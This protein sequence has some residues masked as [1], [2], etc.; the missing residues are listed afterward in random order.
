MTT[1]VGRRIPFPAE[2][3]LCGLGLILR[4][5]RDDDIVSGLEDRLPGPSRLLRALSRLLLRR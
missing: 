3:R 5:W 4:E 1:T 2:V